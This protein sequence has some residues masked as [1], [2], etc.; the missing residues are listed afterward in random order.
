M[1]CGV[2]SIRVKHRLQHGLRPE[3]HL[4]GRRLQDGVVDRVGQRDGQR[5]RRETGRLGRCGKLFHVAQSSEVDTE[6]QVPG[7]Q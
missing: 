6:R 4:A 2:E 1:V 3:P 7:H 5:P